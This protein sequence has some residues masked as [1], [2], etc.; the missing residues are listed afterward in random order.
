VVAKILSRSD[1]WGRWTD[2]VH[3]WSRASGAVLERPVWARL[4][5]VG[6]AS[7]GAD[8]EKRAGPWPGVWGAFELS[9]AGGDER[10]G[11]FEGCDMESTL[12]KPRKSTFGCAWVE[13]L[14]DIAGKAA[15]EAAG[16]TQET[17]VGWPLHGGR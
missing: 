4:F 5:G 17:V 14:A 7:V 10:L 6:G 8:G 13:C 2:G 9:D 11:A 15:R 3:R 16:R 12:V 1:N